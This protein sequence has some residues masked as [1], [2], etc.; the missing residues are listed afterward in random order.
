MAAAA[1]VVV[2]ALAYALYA[3]ARDYLSPAGAAAVVAAAAAA[4]IVI[5]ALMVTRKAAPQSLRRAAGSEEPTL[6][7]RLIE[8]ARERPIVAGA[9]AVAAALVIARNPRIVTTIMTAAIA[10]RA[11]RT[12]EPRKRR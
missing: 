11:A 7:T 1:G 2:V 8:L 10:G 4:L 6:T 3:I 9:G 12:E 5:L